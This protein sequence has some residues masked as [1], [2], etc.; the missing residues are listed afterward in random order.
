MIGNLNMKTE[1]RRLVVHVSLLTVPNGDTYIDTGDND[2][3]SAGS[4]S[5]FQ[6][7]QVVIFC[8]HAG[9]D[10]NDGEGN[11]DKG[12]CRTVHLPN[13]CLWISSDTE[14]IL[15]PCDDDGDNDDGANWLYKIPSKSALLHFHALVDL[16]KYCIESVGQRGGWQ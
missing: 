6:L 15:L 13:A 5:G 9:N 3:V 2:G 14:V 7:Y 12:T 11:R 1:S 8:R 4:G 16:A 10:D